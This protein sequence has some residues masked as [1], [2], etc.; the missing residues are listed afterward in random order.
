MLVDLLLKLKKDINCELD[1]DEIKKLYG[2]DC[3]FDLRFIDYYKKRKMY[4][5]LV[6]VF[7][8]NH[9]ACTTREITKDTICF[10]GSI[11]INEVLPTYN[12]R[13]IF[14]DLGYKLDKIYNLENLEKIY[15]I[16]QF[17]QLICALGLENLEEIIECADFPILRNADG[18]V[19]LKKVF[20]EADFCVLE[21]AEDLENLIYIGSNAN[22][23]CL[24]SAKG[25]ENLEYIGGNA[26]FLKL[27]ST[28]ELL[29]LKEISGYANFKNLK[30]VDLELFEY[31]EL[32]HH[33]NR[34][35]IILDGFKR[36]EKMKC[37]ALKK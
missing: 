3:N 24:Y 19:G 8:D 30:V 10:V 9:V 23:S 4:K 35:Y 25:L 32:M 14:G 15:G 1:V 22:F 16:G 12:L 21:N 28:K 18:L 11:F 2:I 13:Y 37:I 31:M 33:S 36:K 6:K 7:G 5:D 26:E 17:K 27:Q 34:D 20:G 29:N